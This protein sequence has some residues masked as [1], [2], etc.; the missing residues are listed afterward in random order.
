MVDL[1]KILLILDDSLSN[2]KVVVAQRPAPGI[3]DLGALD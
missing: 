1:Q 2:K 3:L